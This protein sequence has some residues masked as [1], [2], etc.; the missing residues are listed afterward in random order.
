MIDI[1]ANLT[2]AAFARD[3]D[4]VLERARQ[5]GLRHIVIT[6]TDPDASAQ[7]LAMANRDPDFLSA[8]AG[9]HPHAAAGVEAGWCERLAALCRQRSVVA[10]GETGLD[11]H[12]NF[13][14]AAA[15]EAVFRQQLE[16]A[17]DLRMPV[18]VHDRDSHG[19]VASI[20]GEYRARLTRV[21]VHCFTGSAADLDA[22]Q[23]NDCYIGITGWVCDERRGHHLAELVP[24]IAPDR[25]LLETD[26]PYLLPRT[27]PDP[28]RSRRNEPAFL[29]RV[30]ERVAEL[31]NEP[32]VDVAALTMAN[33]RRFFALE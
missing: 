13:S 27:L 18:F 8:T 28:P 4:Q 17:I 14:P 33:A 30:G 32:A 12:R 11:F 22:H 26:A 23:A 24:R 15:Q 19:R 2:N 25:L 5:A 1:G 3:I 9:V 21:V 29:T 20:L 31:R 10:V 16:L 6:G 7:A